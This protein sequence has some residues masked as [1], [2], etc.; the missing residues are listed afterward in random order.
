[1]RKRAAWLSLAASAA[2]LTATMASTP[3]GAATTWT[4]QPGGAV[5]AASG[6]LTLWDTSKGGAAIE[7]PPSTVHAVLQSGSGLPGTAIGS[8]TAASFQNCTG[9]AGLTYTLTAGHL[10]W[11]LNVVSYDSSSGT[12]SGTITGVHVILSGPGCAGVVDGTGA[13]QD[14]GTIDI[15]YNNK[16][17]NLSW[18]KTG[19]NLHFYQVSGCGF[20]VSGHPAGFAATFSVSPPQAITSP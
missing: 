4:V 5:T 12:A 9:P 2:L 19:G 20:F 8:V 13:G 18:F 16:T 10:P 15:S 6:N 1:M 7:C 3:A 17:H 11:Q 14:D